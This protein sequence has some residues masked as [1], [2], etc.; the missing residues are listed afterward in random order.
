MISCSRGAVGLAVG[1][2]F[3]VGTE[4]DTSTYAEELQEKNDHTLIIKALPS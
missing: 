2:G 4:V 3:V 1:W